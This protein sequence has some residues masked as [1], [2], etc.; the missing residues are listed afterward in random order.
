MMTFNV[1]QAC[2]ILERTPDVL[3]SLLSGLSE[4]WIQ[5]LEGDK[6]W[7]AYD[8]VG[9]LVHGEKTDWIARMSI[10]LGSQEDR[11]FQ[12]FDRFAQFQESKG[13]SLN[14]LLDEFRRLRRMNLETLNAANIDETK[15]SR[16][17]IH[18]AFGPVTLRQLLSTWVVHDLGHLAQISRVMARQY[19]T[20]VG[21]W[22][23]YL[24]V[25]TRS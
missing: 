15:L 14:D 19:K 2:E 8:I 21:P 11:R 9:H 23:E 3:Q 12:P 22:I 5:G 10:I 13:K 7:S 25:L 16:S 4:E 20:E 17:G 1:R 24:P 18:P 6:T